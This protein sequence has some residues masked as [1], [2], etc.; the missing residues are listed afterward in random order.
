MEV[1]AAVVAL[2]VALVGGFRDN[3][4][5]AHHVAYS[6]SHLPGGFLVG[7]SLTLALAARVGNP[8]GSY[9]VYDIVQA[10]A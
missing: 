4:P 6:G 5:S 2:V 1:V 10:R 9:R 3:L 8:R 7:F